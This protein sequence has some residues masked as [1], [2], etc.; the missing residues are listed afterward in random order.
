M[1]STIE[2]LNGSRIEQARITPLIP[3]TLSGR[4]RERFINVS[5]RVLSEYPVRRFKEYEKEGDTIT[6]AGIRL[7][8]LPFYSKSAVSIPTTVG[9]V[10]P[11][12]QFEEDGGLHWLVRNSG[13]YIREGWR[14]A[15]WWT[16]PNESLGGVRP[17][18]LLNTD[19][20]N[21][22]LKDVV[23]ALYVPRSETVVY[24]E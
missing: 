3:S 17:V 5:F 21:D 16:S 23:N 4:E 1:L 22:E 13:Y 19:R 18:S 14:K 20:Q 9:P 24:E 10:F 7:V 11:T 2:A 15:D 12:F 6:E 8:R